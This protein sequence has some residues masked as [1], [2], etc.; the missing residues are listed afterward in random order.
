MVLS[1]LVVE[2]PKSELKGSDTHWLHSGLYVDTKYLMQILTMGIWKKSYSWGVYLGQ[3]SIVVILAAN[4]RT[5][6]PHIHCSEWEILVPSQ[7]LRRP[8]CQNTRKMNTHRIHTEYTSRTAWHWMCKSTWN[9]WRFFKCSFS[10]DSQLKWDVN[11]LNSCMDG[12]E[13]LEMN[14]LVAVR[15]SSGCEISQCEILLNQA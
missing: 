1:S 15:E 7:P 14:G 8:S 13:S 9:V 3:S 2:W 4:V 12:N 10:V 5:N 11:W 6:Y